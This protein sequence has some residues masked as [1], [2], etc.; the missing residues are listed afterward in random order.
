MS[1]LHSRNSSL[2]ALRSAAYNS[3][4]AT[5]VGQPFGFTSWDLTTCVLTSYDEVAR[6]MLDTPHM[7]QVRTWADYFSVQNIQH[8]DS[9]QMGA[10]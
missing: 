6:S 9:I 1:D 8:K 2:N 10:C 7:E 3:F 5:Y 4:R